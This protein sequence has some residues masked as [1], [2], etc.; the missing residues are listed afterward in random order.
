MH[1]IF[2]CCSISIASRAQ[3]KYSVPL[4]GSLLLD[5]ADQTL[6]EVSSARS[7]R[8]LFE[9]SIGKGNMFGELVPVVEVDDSTLL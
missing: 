1:V 2:S 8:R 3:S 4:P 5:L 7:R 9:G 6:V